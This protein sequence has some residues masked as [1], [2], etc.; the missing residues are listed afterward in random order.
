MKAKNLQKIHETIHKEIHEG[1]FI[2]SHI[3]KEIY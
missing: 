2:R 3:V 1:E